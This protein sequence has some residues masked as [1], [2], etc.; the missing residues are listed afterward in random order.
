MTYL[1]LPVNWL[2]KP[3]ATLT[4]FNMTRFIL[5]VTQLIIAMTQLI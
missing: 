1:N 5:P 2:K 4:S 3:E